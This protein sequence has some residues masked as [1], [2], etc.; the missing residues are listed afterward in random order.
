M[1]KGREP[2][3][4]CSDYHCAGDCGLPGHGAQHKGNDDD[5]EQQEWVISGEPEMVSVRLAPLL[6]LLT[7]LHDSD[8]LSEQQCAK[9]LGW[10]LLDWRIATQPAPHPF[11]QEP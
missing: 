9:Y 1:S 8:Y 4:W 7:A 3:E 10:D 5:P 2:L 11:E 6:E